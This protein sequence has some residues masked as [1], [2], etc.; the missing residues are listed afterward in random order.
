MKDR[1][2][3]N[4]YTALLYPT[5]RYAALEGICPDATETVGQA[6]QHEGGASVKG[7]GAD[8]GDAV[9]QAGQREEGT[10]GEGVVADA[11]EAVG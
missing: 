3:Y 8:A 1:S 9:G 11:G 2:T 7:V 4:T 5:I 10:V 6:G